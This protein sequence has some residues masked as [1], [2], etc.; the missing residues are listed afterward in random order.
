MHATSSLASLVTMAKVRIHS[1]EAGS[2]QL[3]Q[4]PASGSRPVRGVWLQSAL[5]LHGRSNAGPTRR[6]AVPSPPPRRDPAPAHFA[7]TRN[8]KLTGRHSVRTFL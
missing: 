3:F 8:G 2:F 1:P 7:S 5:A 6:H 4:I